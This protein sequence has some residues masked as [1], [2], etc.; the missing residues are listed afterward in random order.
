M[1]TGGF[2]LGSSALTSSTL[3]GCIEYSVALKGPCWQN[4]LMKP[5]QN[6][7]FGGKMHFLNFF[8]K[9]HSCLIEKGWKIGEKNCEYR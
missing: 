1:R 6:V 8:L 2:E 4:F 5:L 3:N 9:K 7:F